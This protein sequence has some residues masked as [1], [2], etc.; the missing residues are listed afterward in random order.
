MFLKRRRTMFDLMF[1]RGTEAL[2]EQRR[3]IGKTSRKCSDRHFRIGDKVRVRDYVQERNPWREGII[4]GQRGQVR[5]VT[6]FVRVREITWKRHTNQLRRI[7]AELGNDEAA[8]QDVE[9]ASLPDE[10]TAICSEHKPASSITGQR[11]VKETPYS[12]SGI[13]V[14]TQNVSSSDDAPFKSSAETSKPTQYL[15][16]WGEVLW[17][18]LADEIRWRT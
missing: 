6:W 3:Q 1:P 13:G 18:R 14:T 12:R 17:C 9:M 2:E 10:E 8:A 15:R 16:N 7:G 11:E 5:Q 4:V